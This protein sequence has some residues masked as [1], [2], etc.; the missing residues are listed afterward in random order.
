MLSVW[1]GATRFEHS[2]VPRHDPVL[3]K[4]FG[5]KCMANFKAIMRFFRKFDQA[6]T[7]RVFGRMYR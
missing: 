2:E 4:L 7:M 5:F 1:C 6:I 3:Q